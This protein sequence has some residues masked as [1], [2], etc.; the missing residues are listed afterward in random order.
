VVQCDYETT[1]NFPVS[2]TIV[3]NRWILAAGGWYFAEY[4]KP[5]D[6]LVIA[7]A[8][9]F[10]EEQMYVH[11]YQKIK[12]GKIAGQSDSPQKGIILTG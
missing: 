8:Y 2:G 11:S 1:R 12:V 5:D 6:L 9:N 3:S 4:I 10:H 7:G